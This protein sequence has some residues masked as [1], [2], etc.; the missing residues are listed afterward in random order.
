MHLY[1]AEHQCSAD[2]CR[3]HQF[4][5]YEGRS[6]AAYDAFGHLLLVL[7]A[8]FILQKHL[9]FSPTLPVTIAWT[10]KP[11]LENMARRPFLISFTCAATTSCL[12]SSSKVLQHY[13]TFPVRVKGGIVCMQCRKLHI[14]II[15][16]E[17]DEHP[18]DLMLYTIFPTSARYREHL[19]LCKATEATGQTGSS[20]DPSK[21][22]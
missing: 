4:V 6:L 19:P 20:S 10:K 22:T 18:F 12:N 5:V 15:L 17:V 13:A 11:K 7:T 16:P 2:V 1:S 14:L 3:T 8:C 21:L 9:G